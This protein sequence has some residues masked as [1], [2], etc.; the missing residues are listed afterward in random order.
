[1]LAY[2]NLS[3]DTNDINDICYSESTIN[4]LQIKDLFH[5]IFIIMNQVQHYSYIGSL[6]NSGHGEK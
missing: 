6:S 1:M 3:I 2:L 5:M 4:T